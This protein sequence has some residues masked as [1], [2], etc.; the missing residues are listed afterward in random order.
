MTSAD[1]QEQKKFSVDQ[2]PP[3]NGKIA[4][5]TG[6]HAGIGLE[7][8]RALA[9]AGAKVY[10]ASRTESKAQDAIAQ[11]RKEHA[12][13]ASQGNTSDA[14]QKAQEASAAGATGSSPAELQLDYVHLDLSDLSTGPR[15]AKDFLAKE[16]QLHIIVCNAGIMGADYE[17]TKD[18]IEQS[19]QVNHLTHFALIQS[20]LPALEAAGKASAPHPARIVN[21]TSIAHKFI[22]ANPALE[23]KFKSL[24]DV[25]RKMGIGELGKYMRYSQGKL[26]NLLMVREFNR[27]HG[28]SVRATAVHPGFIASDLYKGTPLAPIAPKIFASVS[29]GALAS[30]YAATSPDLEKED[31]WDAYRVTFGLEGQDTK[32]SRDEGL[33]KDL[34]DL[35]E[36]LVAEK[37]ASSGSV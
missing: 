4:I 24:D 5:V 3:L 30:L 29:E 19:F 2:I 6:G 36:K 18:G 27:R 1:H 20:L 15:C 37:G 28:A 22:S 13:S 16:S 11:L 25:N 31:S 14:G 23:P 7:T 35:S 26:S 8:T 9:H 10:M 34:W 12:E 32:Y 33:A 21:L 17:L